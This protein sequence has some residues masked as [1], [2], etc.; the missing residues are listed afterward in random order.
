MGSARQP[1][2]ASA[3]LMQYHGSRV[4]RASH[5]SGRAPEGHPAGTAGERRTHDT[6]HGLLGV[7][8]SL[9]HGKKNTIR[10][11]AGTYTLT[12][13][14]NLP[15]VTS[16]LTI[17]G[18]GDDATVIARSS[19]SSGGL[20]SVET[21]G[22]LK[23]LTLQGGASGLGG[24]IFN[25]GTLT[26]FQSTLTHN[27]TLEVQ[28]TILALNTQSDCAGAI[29][30]LG[31]NLIGD[32]TGCTITLQAI[33]LQAITLQA[34]TLQAITLQASDLTGDPGFDAFTDDG[35]PGHG[36][37]PLLPGSPAID[38]GNDAACPPTDQL[39]QR[40]VG[41]CDIGAIRFPDTDDRQHDE[42]RREGSE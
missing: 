22:T 17:R 8:G 31:T 13:I 26:L 7:S 14:D 25:K 23:R 6:D 4:A 16:T 29:T 9:A 27:T 40:R 15:S 42:G 38:A 18:A 10:L 32:P 3:T 5:G 21:T 33:T 24:G 39:G 37:F 1:S 35:T 34:S 2:A 36:Y 28:N 11:E 30:S 12:A 19:L 41:P 20:V